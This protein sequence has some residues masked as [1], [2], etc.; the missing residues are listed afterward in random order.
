MRNPGASAEGLDAGWLQVVPHSADF[1]QEGFVVTVG[2][3]AE[4]VLLDPQPQ[5]F[6]GVLLGSS[7]R[8]GQQRDVGRD[9]QSLAGMPACVVQHQDNMASGSHVP[10]DGLQMQVHHERVR[11]GQHQRHRIPRLGVDGPE[12]VDPLIL[13]LLGA[14]GPAAPLRPYAGQGTLLT[15]AALVLEPDFDL[16][17]GMSLSHGL[18]KRGALCRHCSTTWVSCLGFLGRGRR[19]A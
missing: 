7:R 14:D 5:A 10:A 9:V 11:F 18:D 2:P 6:D 16:L 12:Q 17:V 1:L 13:G 3:I 15:E 19:G 4:V 8:Q